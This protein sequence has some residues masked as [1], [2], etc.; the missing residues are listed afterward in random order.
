LQDLTPSFLVFCNG[1]DGGND[2][3]KVI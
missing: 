2:G 3:D 1:K